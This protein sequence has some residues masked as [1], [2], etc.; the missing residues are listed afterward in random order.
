MLGNLSGHEV[1]PPRHIDPSIETCTPNQFI[2]QQTI[3]AALT[4]VAKTDCYSGFRLL[5]TDA[6]SYNAPA[7]SAL[8]NSLYPNLTQTACYTHMLARLSAKLV[9]SYP[10]I[11]KLV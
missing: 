9:D 10:D 8:K 5:L 6:A 11:N 4:K 3:V 2:V 7:A 1:H